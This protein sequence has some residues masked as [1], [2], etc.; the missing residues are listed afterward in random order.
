MRRLSTSL[1]HI[2]TYKDDI[3]KYPQPPYIEQVDGVVQILYG[4]FKIALSSNAFRIV[5]KDRVPGVY[6]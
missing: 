3:I 5:Q 4:E 2:M 1:T 6:Y